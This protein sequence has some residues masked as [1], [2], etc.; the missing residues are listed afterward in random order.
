M[1][2][3]HVWYAH[4][5]VML[6]DICL[7]QYG[8]QECDSGYGYGP[9]IRNF[10]FIHYVYRGKGHLIIEGKRFDIEAGQYF[11]ICPGQMAYYE[12]D[13]EDPWEY[14]WFEISGA[15]CKRL[16]K[17]SGFSG[18][19]PVI[20][21]KEKRVGNA[22]LALIRSEE[23]PFSA[24]LGKTWEILHAMTEN[25][26]GFSAEVRGEDY[27]RKCETYIR[28]NLH[29]KLRVAELAEYAGID[30]SYL[31]RL[32]K[33]HKGL[34]PQQY[35]LK[36]KMEAVAQYL[37]K[38]ETTV[39]ETALCVGY[40]DPLEFSKQFRKQFRVSPTEWRKKAFYEQS[41]QDYMQ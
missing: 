6:Q 29:K 22:V 30:R 19:C 21:D 9:C 12:A 28:M 18:N 39:K 32:F 20:C 13:K 41:I 7:L 26:G 8:E 36:L 37:K 25:G 27:V 4:T 17:Q 5:D 34:S 31:S 38:E 35:I 14:R 40:E 23:A 2:L 11:L 16:M 1:G 3:F 33:E 24:L 15:L 10:Y